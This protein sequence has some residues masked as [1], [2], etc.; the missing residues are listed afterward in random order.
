M[1]RRTVEVYEQRAD[2]WAAARPGS[3]ASQARARAF[4]GRFGQGQ[5]RLDLGCGPGVHLVNLGEPIV[6]VDASLAM[7]KLA[8]EA[9]PSGL[10]VCADLEAPPFRRGS[11]G[12]VWASK[13]YQVESCTTLDGW[14]SDHLA[15]IAVLQP[16]K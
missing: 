5:I 14:A 9:A 15:V 7:L 2:D 16:V 8:G 6:A 11:I 3:T 12:G 10:R 13:S 1:D 4:A